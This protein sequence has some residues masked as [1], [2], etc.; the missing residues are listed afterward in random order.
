MQYRQHYRLR[1][2]LGFYARS[3]RLR[4]ADFSGSTPNHRGY[5]VALG[6]YAPRMAVDDG[7]LVSYDDQAD[8][9]VGKIF[10]DGS[11]TLHSGE[12]S[13]RFALREVPS[14]DFMDSGLNIVGRRLNERISC[15][16]RGRDNVAPRICYP[17]SDMTVPTKLTTRPTAAHL[18][19]SRAIFRMLLSTWSRNSTDT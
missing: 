6:G 2:C 3:L 9:V 16:S 14:E 4:E 1:G 7:W 19:P 11:A 10:H 12:R 13:R 5:D 18:R 17:Q 8:S 15:T